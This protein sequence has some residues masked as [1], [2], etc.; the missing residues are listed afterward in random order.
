MECTLSYN[1]CPP[2]FSSYEGVPSGDFKTYAGSIADVVPFMHVGGWP[3][4]PSWGTAGATIPWE[5]MS[6]VGD[7]SVA[8]RF[9]NSTSRG[10][11]DFLSAQGDPAHK[12]LV[13]FGYYGDWLA[14][15]KGPNWQVR[16]SFARYCDCRM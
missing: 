2:P 8:K 1:V 3:G 12:G 16:Q 9:Y 11:V 4:D 5:V 10:F 6:Q 15:D 7:K 14:L 13:R